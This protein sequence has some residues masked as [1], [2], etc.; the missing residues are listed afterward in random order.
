MYT[1]I[2]EFLHNIDIDIS[3]PERVKQ[4]YF[5]HQ[6]TGWDSHNIFGS[7]RFS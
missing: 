1:F 5:E 2:C 3:I 4:R 7:I 6:L